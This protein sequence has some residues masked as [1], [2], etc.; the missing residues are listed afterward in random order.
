MYDTKQYNTKPSSS[1]PNNL[2][3]RSSVPGEKIFNNLPLEIEIVA[4]NQKKFNP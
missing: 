1:K 3:K 2:S 4:D